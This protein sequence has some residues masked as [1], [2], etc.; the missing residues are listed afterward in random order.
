MSFQNLCEKNVIYQYF[1]NELA[2]CD[3]K[4]FDLLGQKKKKRRFLSPPSSVS[5]APHLSFFQT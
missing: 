3:I 4:I 1:H 5:T 2:S